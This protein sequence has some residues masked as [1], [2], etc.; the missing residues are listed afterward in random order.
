MR[1]TY[2]A[3]VRV[4]PGFLALTVLAGGMP[5]LFACAPAPVRPSEVAVEHLILDLSVDFTAHRLSGRVSL[6]LR[7]R[8]GAVA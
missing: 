5:W 8:T 3:T 1:Q 7:N 4:P 6:R 2:E